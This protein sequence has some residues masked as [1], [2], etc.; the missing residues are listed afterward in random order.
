TAFF[1]REPEFFIDN[2]EILADV[3][4][5]YFTDYE[6]VSCFVAMVQEKTVG[7]II[8]TRDVSMMKKIFFRKILSKFIVRLIRGRVF[9][10]KR[11][12]LFSLNVLRS[13]LRGEFAAPDF[14]GEYPA[15]LHINIDKNF[16]NRGLGSR[17]ITMY[18]AYLKE[19]MVKG[20]H[21]G[22]MSN[23]AKEFFLKSE[24]SILYETK[25]TWP[26]YYFKKDMP[27]YIFGKVL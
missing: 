1:E 9:F 16:R 25:R 15:T 13:V 5:L 17:L 14:S 20:V 3:L 23:G 18:L 7:Y 11:F 19:N 26:R 24:F 12:L 22:T 2:N 6:P 4:T 21:F 27:Y 10:K 8:G